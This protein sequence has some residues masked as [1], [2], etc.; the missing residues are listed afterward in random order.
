[1]LCVPKK[2]KKRMHRELYCL[3]EYLSWPPEGKE[4]H[5]VGLKPHWDEA[6]SGQA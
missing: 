1:M 4:I 3:M 6:L 5:T 2:K